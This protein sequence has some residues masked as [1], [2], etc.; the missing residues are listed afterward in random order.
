MSNWENRAKK[1]SARKQAKAMTKPFKKKKTDDLQHE[2]KKRVKIR[3]KQAQKQNRV[4][5]DNI[6]DIE[7]SENLRE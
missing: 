1:V 7:D 3:I 2:N 4:Y 5:L 6:E